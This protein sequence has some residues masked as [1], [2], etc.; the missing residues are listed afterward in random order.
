M[1]LRR[2]A[3]PLLATVFVWGGV[4][5]LRHLEGH[6]EAAKPFLDKTIGENSEKLP[7]AVPT[8]PRTLVQAD[9]W[10]KIGAG[11]ALALGKLPR[12]SALLLA[13]SLVPTTLAAHQFW[14][15]E[16][17]GER[18]R[19][20]TQFLK[21]LGLL[22][23]LMI[24]SADT[25]GRPSLGWWARRTARQAGMKAQDFTETVADTV[26]EAPRRVRELLPG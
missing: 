25:E 23:G 20:E 4:N 1:I 12:L 14:T 11:L 9:A 15:I 13:G 16:D 19:Q 26:S 17:E 22:G 10:I 6:V 3:R 24:A 18:A 7:D 21:N 8:E 5:A 2:V